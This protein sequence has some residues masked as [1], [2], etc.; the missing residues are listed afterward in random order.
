M[1]LL[2]LR[3][4]NFECLII[5]MHQL[6]PLNSYQNQIDREYWTPRI[7]VLIILRYYFWKEYL[8]LFF[9]PQISQEILKFYPLFTKAHVHQFFS[10]YS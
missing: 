8:L 6:C 5:C 1:N 9:P 10:N 7:F 4:I 2:I 3:Q